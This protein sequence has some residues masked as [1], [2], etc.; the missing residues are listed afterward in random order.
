MRFRRL[1]PP[2]PGEWRRAP[3]AWVRR[4]PRRL[5]WTALLLTVLALVIASSVWALTRG[6]PAADRQAGRSAGAAPPHRPPGAVVSLTFDDGRASQ[7][8]YARPLLQQYGM[9][10]TFYV[11]TGPADR[12][13]ECCLSW[14]QVMQLYRDGHEIGGTSADGEDL[15]IPASPDP[16]Q[17]YAAK[18]QQV[19]GARQRLAGLGLDPRSFAYPEGKQD[20]KFPA[21]QGTLAELVASCGYL[22]GRVIGGLSPAGPPYPSAIEL[23]PRHPFALPTPE[24][25]SAAPIT[26]GQ[27]QESVLAAGK[28]WVPLVLREVCHAADPSYSSCM[29]TSGP[30]DDAVLS[31]FL[32]WL[33]GAGQPGGAPQDTTVQTVRQVMGAPAPPVMHGPQ[34]LVSLTFDDGDASQDLAGRLMKA[35]GLH[36]TFFVNTGP[37]D[38][39]NPG[40]MTWAQVLRLHMQGNEIGGHT[41]E[42]VDLTDPQTSRSAKRAEVCGD[43]ARLVQMGL[44]PRSFAYPYGKLDQAAERLVQSCG[45]RSARSAGTVAPDGPIAAETVPPLDPF[46]TRA[47]DSPDGPLTLA[48]LQD[49]VV[50]AAKHGGGWVQVVIHTV[51]ASDDPEPD[52]CMSAEAP[53]EERVFID[54]LDWLQHDAPDGTTVETVAQ[55]LGGRR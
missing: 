8:R 49:A 1:G 34:T 37:I 55:A 5:R 28:G 41:A 30:I 39:N 53:I 4:L 45:Y 15:T 19:C 10:G 26:L 27:L 3:R 40:H 54:F 18:K 32:A 17:D 36:G 47:L 22:S 46:A 44:D 29:S 20:Y 9:S 23:P 38:R 43:R 6:S 51:C 13:G 21:G 16:A 25:P 24:E 42:H 12:G 35:R 2:A 31:A 50:A 52:R 7:Y 33:H 11:R 14:P 48:Y